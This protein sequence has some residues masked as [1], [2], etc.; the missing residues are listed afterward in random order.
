MDDTAGISAIVGGERATH[1]E[2]RLHAAIKARA[3]ELAVPHVAGTGALFKSFF[4]G[5]FE[6]ST[7]RRRDGKRLDLIA[8]TGHDV[9][10]EADYRML[11]AHGIRTVRGGLRWHLIET[12]PRR[13]D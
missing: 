9:N 13:Y 3:A 7:H 2:R 10:A 8:A 12:A 6:C 1:N 11:A 4:I 5:G